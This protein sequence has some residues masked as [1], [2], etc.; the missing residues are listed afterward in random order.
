[1]SFEEIKRFINEKI[2]HKNEPKLL[3]APNSSYRFEFDEKIDIKTI[4]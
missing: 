2:F 1:M 3:N 4:M